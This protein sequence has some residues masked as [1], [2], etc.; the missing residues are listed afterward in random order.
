MAVANDLRILASKAMVKQ[1]QHGWRT[2]DSGR[3]AHTIRPVVLVK[4]WFDGQA[5]ERSFVT[6]ISRVI[7]GHRIVGDPICVCMMNY[8]TVDHFIWECSRF[9]VERHQ[10][11]LGHATVNK[12]EGNTKSGSLRAAEVGSIEVMPQVP[13]GM[14]PK[15]MRKPFYFGF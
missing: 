10:L 11:L 6:T 2:A 13:K 1:W 3:F 9:E 5:E 15:N 14:W 12:K 7:S 8:A 4:P